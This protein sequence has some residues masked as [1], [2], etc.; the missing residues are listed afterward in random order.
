MSPVEA[1]AVAYGQA[2]R[3]QLTRRRLLATYQCDYRFDEEGKCWQRA[4]CE[5]QDGPCEGCLLRQPAYQQWRTA[6]RDEKKALRVL[7]QRL[8]GASPRAEKE[9]RSRGIRLREAS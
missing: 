9:R 3:E 4:C 6:L 7:Q 2:R 1:A 5:L 8:G